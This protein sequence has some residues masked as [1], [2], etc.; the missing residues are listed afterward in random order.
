M[1][2]DAMVPDGLD[3]ATPNV[4]RMYDYFLGG[5]D[6]FAADREAAS[7]ILKV[8]PDTPV[9]ARA[10]RDF[11]RRAVR[12]LSAAGISQFLDVGSGLPTQGN[13]HELAADARV[14]YV[15]NDP[16]VLCHARALL[17]G[18]SD[19]SIIQADL[20]DPESILGHRDLNLDLS[21]PVALLLVAV[22]HFVT[23]DEAPYDILARFRDALPSGS[24]VVISHLTTEG[25]PEEH[26]RAGRAAYQNATAPIVP[27]SREGIRRFFDG[28]ELVDPGLTRI[29]E[30][31][32]D[33]PNTP[34]SHG[35]AGV[36]RRP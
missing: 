5:K 6:N 28:L 25:V 35:F 18:A 20:R 32:P 12:H 11:M 8:F 31:R 30:W 26:V 16:M 1:T 36:A 10:N 7:R 4:A 2:M 17:G 29:A 24:H 14:T 27:R 34:R 9:A 23:D 15:D 13:V 3:I 19:V 33:D 21:R 22:L